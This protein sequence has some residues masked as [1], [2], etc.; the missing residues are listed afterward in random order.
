MINNNGSN[1]TNNLEWQWLWKLKLPQR[2]SMFLWLF[3]QNKILT[4]VACLSWG[5]TDNDNCK[6]CG[7]GEDR[8]H[9]FRECLRAK[10]V[11]NLI[12]P[13]VL[14]FPNVDFVTL[15]D[16]NLRNI[17]KNSLNSVSWNTVFAS[18]IWHIWKM[19]NEFQF[20]NVNQSDNEVVI[21]SINFTS[22][23]HDA[24]N[25]DDLSIINTEHPLIGWS[26]PPGGSTKINTDGSCFNKNPM[27]GSFRGLARSE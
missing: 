11:R 18:T 22:W 9:I 16:A 24:F 2:I 5:I 26:F 3:R 15:L 20:N 14:I 23:I 8:N 4:N 12:S 13:N 7:Y 21:K 1:A 6:K 17:N 10:K 25:I 19:R 27:C